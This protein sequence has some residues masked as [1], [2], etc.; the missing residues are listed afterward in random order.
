[1]NRIVTTIYL[2]FCLLLANSSFGQDNDPLSAEHKAYLFYTVGKSPILQNHIG[3]FF[4]YTGTPILLANGNVN[5][6]STAQYIIAFPD[7]LII[8]ASEIRKSPRGLV[9]ELTN[10]MAVWELNKV[11]NS[12]RTNELEK[13][14][15][16]L[17]YRQFLNHFTRQLP[18]NAFMERGGERVLYPKVETIFHP[19]LA[20]TD[21]LAILDGLNQLSIKEKQQIIEALSFAINQFVQERSYL[22]YQ[23]IGGDAETFINVL[24][25]AGDGSNN[26]EFFE[27]REKDERGRWNRGLPKAIGLF[28]YQSVITDDPTRKGQTLRPESFAIHQFETAGGGK[29]TTVHLD[30]W[31]YSSDRQTTVVLDKGGAIYPLFGNMETRFLAPDSL[32]KGGLTF[33]ALIRRLNKEIQ[34]IEQM[35]SGKKGFDYWIAYH[36]KKKKGKLLQID[37][38]EKEL[39]D[40]RMQPITTTSKGKKKDKKLVADS[41]QKKRHPKQETFLRYYAELAAINK[42]IKELK[43]LREKA[44][45]DQQILVQ[46]VKFMQDLIGTNWVK[47]KQKDGF[48]IF[49]DK[50][51]FD[52]R[53]QAFTF[54][55]S[56]SSEVFEI[57][58]IAIPND[59]KS[60]EA[61]EVMLHINVMESTPISNARIQLLLE[62]INLSNHEDILLPLFKSNDSISVRMFLESLLEK[63]K[64]F[65]IQAI[66]G[67]I[68][69][70]NGFHT[71]SDSD[72]QSIA[73]YTDQ[74]KA[75]SAEPREVQRLNVT[76]VYG[77]T[78]RE[79]ILQVNS[80]TNLQK[81]DFTAMSAAVQ[82]KMRANNWSENQVMTAYQTRTVLLAL[83]NELN[84]AA[85][86]FF[87]VAQAK[88]IT[89]RLNAQIAKTKIQV[90][91]ESLTLKEM[92]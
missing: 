56:D 82:S 43:E 69:K 29:S 9:A 68:G 5:H 83:Q 54:P 52:I 44:I 50:A 62:A 51:T 67:G 20:L 66:G 71:V 57:R 6:D 70:W 49:D 34:E 76:Q 17:L 12:N 19:G 26:S 37:K 7:S 53:T 40:M 25:A 87:P 74:E 75:I 31:G 88:M 73:S 61:D 23:R 90:G 21:K 63:K 78:D 80:Y 81:R 18:D 72:A 22:F 65:R 91:K 10:K 14:G 32:F 24:T 84:Q 27:E 39:S 59:E 77:F 42:K 11:L 33:Y 15:Y 4:E 64:P 58:L 30:V 86:E 13:D 35:I 45:H 36:E 38:I 48:Y 3:R 47:F 16:L 79:T 41:N 2:F 28:P 60:N 89:K 55:V 92:K 85:Y 46:R 1:M 8:H